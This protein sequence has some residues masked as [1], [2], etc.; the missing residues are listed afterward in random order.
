[1]TFFLFFEAFFG[2]LS[3]RVRRA[4]KL[5]F[6]DFYKLKKLSFNAV[7]ILRNFIQLE[8]SLL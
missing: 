4:I 2:F 5:F 3:F 8:L 6:L 7:T 1:M